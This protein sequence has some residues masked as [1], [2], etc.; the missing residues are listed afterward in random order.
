LATGKA[1]TNKHRDEK[2]NGGGERAAPAFFN[3]LSTA[4]EKFGWPGMLVLFWMYV[5]VK[6]WELYT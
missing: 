3:L 4:V 2:P 1:V 5:V 6:F